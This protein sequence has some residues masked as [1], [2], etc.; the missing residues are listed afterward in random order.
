MVNFEM[1]RISDAFFP[2]SSCVEESWTDEDVSH[3]NAFVS[4][5]FEHE[6]KIAPPQDGEGLSTAEDS[7]KGRKGR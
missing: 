7:V 1:T 6:G 4:G 3:E 5:E 2:H